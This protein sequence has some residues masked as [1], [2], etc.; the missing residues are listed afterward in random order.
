MPD[1]IHAQRAR[2]TD[3]HAEHRTLQERRPMA[4]VLGISR[5]TGQSPSSLPALRIASR[6]CRKC[7]HL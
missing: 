2:R 3:A 6:K 1:K 5:Q 4:D 7:R